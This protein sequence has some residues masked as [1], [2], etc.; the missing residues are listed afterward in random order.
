MIE[1]YGFE[2][3]IIDLF[4]ETTTTLSIAPRSRPMKVYNIGASKV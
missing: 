1:A 3:M 4:S 2:P